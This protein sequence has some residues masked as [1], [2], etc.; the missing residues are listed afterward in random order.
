V[1][2]TPRGGIGVRRRADMQARE[3]GAGADRQSGAQAQPRAGGGVP[4]H[5]NQNVPVHGIIAAP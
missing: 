4:A 2:Q 5:M 3:P 1:E